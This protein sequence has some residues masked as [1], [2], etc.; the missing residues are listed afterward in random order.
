MIEPPFSAILSLRWQCQ[1][2]GISR[3]S[4]YYQQREWLAEDLVLM[5]LID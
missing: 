3:S 4:L 5:R 2:L 1:L